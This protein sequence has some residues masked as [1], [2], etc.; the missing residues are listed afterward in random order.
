MLYIMPSIFI[1][2]TNSYSLL[3]RRTH[4]GRWFYIRCCFN[5][6]RDFK[7][8]LLRR[9]TQENLRFFQVILCF[10]KKLWYVKNLVKVCCRI[11]ALLGITLTKSEDALRISDLTDHMHSTLYTNRFDRR[12]S[13]VLCHNGKIRLLKHSNPILYRSTIFQTRVHSD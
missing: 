6:N 1:R 13:Y 12:T 9:T 11:H 8:I 7:C 5:K 3:G 4:K 10:S 2:Q